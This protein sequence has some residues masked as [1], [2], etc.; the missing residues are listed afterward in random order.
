[1]QCE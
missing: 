1:M